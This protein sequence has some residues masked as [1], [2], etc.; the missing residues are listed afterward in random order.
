M[1][2]SGDSEMSY[3][4]AAGEAPDQLCAAGRLAAENSVFPV[5]PG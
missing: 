1:T 2:P 4:S 3:S 5:S